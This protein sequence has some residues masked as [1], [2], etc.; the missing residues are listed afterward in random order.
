MR[1][2][3]YFDGGKRENDAGAGWYVQASWDSGTNVNSSS[4]GKVAC[5]SIYLAD[6]TVPQAE[7]QGFLEI[8]KA[9][10]LILGKGKVEFD[11]SSRVSLH[12]SNV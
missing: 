2:E 6:S 7:M 1:I 10:M 11:E 8:V 4:W 5:G 12:F 3:G 9:L